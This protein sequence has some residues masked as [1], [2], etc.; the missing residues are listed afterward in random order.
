MSRFVDDYAENGILE[1]F[2]MV[3][4]VQ[5]LKNIFTALKTLLKTEQSIDNV[6]L[7]IASAII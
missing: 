6:C 7:Q 1:S 2:T 3:F 4:C 5:V